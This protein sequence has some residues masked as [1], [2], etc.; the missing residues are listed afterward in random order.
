MAKDMFGR[1]FTQNQ[2][3]WA[4]KRKNSKKFYIHQKSSRGAQCEDF[5]S[6]SGRT[7]ED[8]AVIMIRSKGL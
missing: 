8:L 1:E 5:R 6:S 4:E 7:T 2:T 3:F